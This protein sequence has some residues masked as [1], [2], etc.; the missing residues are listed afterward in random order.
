[1]GFNYPCITPLNSK[2]YFAADDSIHGSELWVSDGTASGTAMVRD[3]CPG[4]TSSAPF[5]FSA[6]AG[7]YIH[8]FS[9]Y[10][11]KLYFRAGDGVHG[12]E[13][14]A[15][16]GTTIGTALVS[17]IWPGAGNSNPFA[18]T[19][20][21]TK[22]LFAAADSL[23]G[24]ELWTSDG[25]SAGTAMVKDLNPGMHGSDPADYSAFTLYNSKLY[26]SASTDAT[27]YELWSTDGTTI[28]TTQ[29][30]DIWPGPGS[31]HP[32][33]MGLFVYNNRLFFNAADSL[34]SSQLWTSD[35]TPGGTSLFKV[36]SSYTPYHSYPLALINY[37]NRMVFTAG[38]DSINRVQ[39]WTSDGTAAGTHILA[40]AI[41]PN[42]NPLGYNYGANPLVI[43]NG[44]LF[45]NANFNTI[46][47]ELW[48]YS[49]PTGITE[50][51]GDHIIT[52]YPNPFSTSVTLSG[53]QGSDIYTV[54]ILDVTGREYFSTEIDHP[55]E[56]NTIT[57][58]E[59]YTGIY[60]MHVSGQ[61]SSQ[62][63]KLVKN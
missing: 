56:S 18:M 55:S 51:S 1:M 59:L 43:A 34:N 37:N 45:M 9:E 41:A 28:G 15:T 23:H 57:M 32:G 13:L 58:P 22:I 48:V 44:S 30:K 39:L 25:T 26:F 19:V 35:G 2:V 20:F 16:D 12:T 10:N 11:G 5:G 4:T 50:A 27:G 62:T 7:Y 40:P 38:T 54:Q 8:Q 14:W 24:M 60:L 46:G 17:D 63:F 31:S 6:A 3:I 21:N 47:D 49:T 36:L 42:S 52:A 53:L 29:V 33:D 61:S